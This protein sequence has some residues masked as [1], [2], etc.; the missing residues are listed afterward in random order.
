MD[1]SPPDVLP[2]HPTPSQQT[3]TPLTNQQTDTSIFI[4]APPDI[5]PTNQQ[6]YTD[7][8]TNQTTNNAILD[9]CYQ[10][11]KMLVE[12]G[13]EQLSMEFPII[14]SKRGGVIRGMF[15][16]LFSSP[17]LSSL[18]LLSPLHH[19]TFLVLSLFVYT[20]Q[21]NC[22]S[23]NHYLGYANMT[24]KNWEQ[25]DKHHMVART[26]IT[27][28]VEVC[29]SDPHTKEA[30]PIVSFLLLPSPVFFSLSS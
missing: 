10:V 6:T 5:L 21:A 3:N 8:Q 2:T 28:S 1:T 26:N 18:L 14:E 9:I 19:S 7:Q 13:I 30:Y 16:L 20:Q 24:R 12:N 15:T 22:F 23:D 4:A 27:H 25:L 11:R 17:L 29:L